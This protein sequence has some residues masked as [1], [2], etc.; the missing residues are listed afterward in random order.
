MKAKY[1]LTIEAIDDEGRTVARC[2][3]AVTVK[4]MEFSK[5]EQE[6]MLAT[7]GMLDPLI[8]VASL[9]DEITTTVDGPTLDRPGGQ[10]N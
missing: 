3:M 9:S 1:T 4:P 8:R 7:K 5:P 6:L 10:P 2:T